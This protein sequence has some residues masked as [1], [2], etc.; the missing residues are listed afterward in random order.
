MSYDDD[1]FKD[2][3]MPLPGVITSFREDVKE[4]IQWDVVQTSGELG[5]GVDF[6]AGVLS[7][8]LSGD[9]YSQRVQLQQ[10]I[11]ARVSP[12]N[13][14]TLSEMAK[15]Y[16]GQGITL[17]VLQIAEQARVNKIAGKFAAAKGLDIEP[18]GHEKTL[19]K[20]LATAGDMRSWDKAV[21]FTVQ[22]AG[23]KAFDSFASGIRS[24]NPEWSKD[25]R[26]LNKRLGKTFDESV[27]ELGDTSPLNFG[28]GVV[29]P[30]GLRHTLYAATEIAEY[31]SA[32]YRAPQSIKALRQESDDKRARDWGDANEDGKVDSKQTTL[33]T[34]DVPDDFE[35]AYDDGEFGKL[36]WAEGLPLTVE[37][38][39]YMRRK[40]RGMQSGRRVSYPSRL[41]TDPER[42]IFSQKVKVKGGIVVVDISGSMSLTQADI[43]SIVE[44][45]P[46]AVI[47][48]YSDCGENSPN[49]WLLANRGWRV[50]HIDNIGGMNNGVDGTALTWA[51]RHKKYGEDIVWISDGQITSMSGGQRDELAVQ[52][53][54]LIKKHRIIMIP[55]VQEA[56][57][58]FK[59]GKLINK[60]AGPIRDALLGKL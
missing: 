21:E 34:S 49:A 51:I 2:E 39:G 31:M 52:C 18:D 32:G 1:I 45:A 35:F 54:K 46:A 57:A 36:V 11:K 20:R 8:P 23:T 42:R 28:N 59:K 44:S 17:G 24:V 22:T 43:E 5:V 56:V 13:D 33:D 53:A 7:V 9:S 55:S 10:L 6:T 60:P 41:L 19:G 16:K 48:A 25:L 15:H 29:G 50:S 37:V 14:K 27:Q 4:P 26:N 58:M 38:K 40:K 3:V 30:R 12:I 47:M